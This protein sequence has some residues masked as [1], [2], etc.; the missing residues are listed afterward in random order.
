MRKKDGDGTAAKLP[1]KV[2]SVLLLHVTNVDRRCDFARIRVQQFQVAMRPRV[3]VTAVERQERVNGPAKAKLP[4]GRMPASLPRFQIGHMHAPAVFLYV[5]VGDPPAAANPLLAR[6]AVRVFGVDSPRDNC[7]LLGR[8]VKDDQIPVMPVGRGR[9]V[10]KNARAVRAFRTREVIRMDGVPARLGRDGANRHV[11]LPR[12]QRVVRR[13]RI[14]SSAGKHAAKE[15]RA[16]LR[17]KSTARCA[18][19]THARGSRCSLHGSRLAVKS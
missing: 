9:G 15:C 11:R 19:R 10:E 6:G 17:Q 8:A 7:F 4:V 1:C 5:V 12:R 13:G 16:G 14:G 2:I 3:P 18:T